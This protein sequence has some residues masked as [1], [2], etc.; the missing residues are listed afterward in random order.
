LPGLG[1]LAAEEFHDAELA[2]LAPE[3]V[4]VC[5]GHVGAVVGEVADGDGGRAIGEDVVMDLENL[6]RRLQVGDGKRRR[7]A[8]RGWRDRDGLTGPS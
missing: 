6:T 1:A 4:V 5:E 8:W 3:G 2:H 7:I